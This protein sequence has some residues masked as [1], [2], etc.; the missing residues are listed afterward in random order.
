MNY[1]YNK[2]LYFDIMQ[3]GIICVFGHPEHTYMS[4]LF[5][6]SKLGTTNWYHS[7]TNC[8]TINLVRNGH[9]LGSCL[10]YFVVFNIL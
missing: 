1:R 3:F 6:Y 8:R 7:L 2:V 10:L 4:T 5:C 9:S